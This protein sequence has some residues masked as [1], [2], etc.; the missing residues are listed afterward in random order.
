MLLCFFDNEGIVHKESVPPGHMVNGK[1]YCDVLRQ[2][3]ENIQHKCPD[4]WRNNS[5][6]LHHDNILAHTL[7]VV[8]QFLASMNTTVT[9]HPTYSLDLARDFFLFP[10]MKFNLK[11]QCFGSNE[12][13][14]NESQDAMKTLT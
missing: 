8:Q 12:E 10:K 7:L 14:Q 6:A 1:F 4:K 5:W 11:G 2:I 9:P 3:R 13:T